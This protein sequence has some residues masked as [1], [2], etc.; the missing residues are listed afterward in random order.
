MRTTGK[1][2]VAAL[3]I[4]AGMISAPFSPL[5]ATFVVD[6]PADSHD[7][8]PGDGVAGDRAN[9][10]SSRCTLRAA[11]EEASALPGADTIL[12]GPAI[13]PIFLTL[14]EIRIEGNATSVVGV[15][16]PVIDGLHNVRFRPSLVFAADSC[17]MQGMVVKRSR[18][19]A[20]QI[21][22]S[23]CRIGDSTVD[24]RIILV[25]NG[26]DNPEAAAIRICGRAARANV[27]LGNY[28]GVDAGGLRAEPNR[29][30]IVI[31][32][33]AS[34]NIVGGHDEA[35]R[36]IISGNES[37]GLVIESGASLNKVAGNYIGTTVLA[38][39]ALGNGA[40]GLLVR[41]GANR[42]LIGGPDLTWGN[43][44]S[45]NAGSGLALSGPEVAQNTI[46]GNVIGLD[47]TGRLSLGNLADGIRL[48]SGAHANLIGGPDS[49]SGNIVSG[50]AGSGI[51]I[52]GPGSDDNN[53]VANW[54][55]VTYDGFGDVGNGWAGGDGITI[56]AAACRN[57]IGGDSY[58]ERNVVSGNYRFG[59]HLTGIGTRENL[60]AGN[61]VGT[62]AAGRSSVF[63]SAGVVIS[64]GASHNEVGGPESG[65]GNVLSGNRAAF[66]PYGAGLLIYGAGSDYN[67]VRGNLIG[68]DMRGERALRNGSAGVIIG[69]GARYNIV[70]GDAPGEGNYIAGNGSLGPIPGVA[71]GVHLY[72]AGTS[73]NRI[74]GNRIGVGPGKSGVVLSNAGHGV[75]LFAG[76]ADNIIG[77]PTP[78]GGNTI[79]ASEGHGV[80]A[81][82][83]KTRSNLIRCNLIF[84]NDSLGL[85][86]SD[87]SQAGIRP[88][89]LT[90]VDPSASGWL[91]RGEQAPPYGLVDIYETFD[92]DPSGAGEGDRYLG[93]AA[94]DSAGHFDFSLPGLTTATTTL[95]A[96]ATDVEDNTSEFAHNF[97]FGNPTSADDSPALLPAAFEL[98]FN[99]PN[100]FNGGTVI[101]FAL[102]RA[103]HTTLAIYNILGQEVAVLLDRRLSPGSYEVSWDGL[104]ASGV[105]AA[106]G[107][108][109]YRLVTDSRS[110]TRK[111]LLVK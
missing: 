109:F 34:E 111:M 46:N 95:T 41:D 102:P 108:Y 91:L 11:V 59:I 107:V 98:L 81:S 110:E 71:A 33:S 76:A 69:G 55:G 7:L 49:V 105:P 87:S 101:T 94:A 100:P 27:V 10:D 12:V 51:R 96:I 8:L 47:A 79:T 42:N 39:A 86:V 73:F 103:A 60:I 29:V 61:Y 5:A 4:L 16:S 38:D 36:N 72:G 82:G 75:G 80:I 18:D 24:G 15:G 70:G 19:D 66:F 53:I 106:S 30:G 43:L 21:L 6:S 58:Q 90:A 48:D 20:I 50:N 89:L 92:P 22:G 56:E 44:I 26:L 57:R 68:L 52:V 40:A 77:G 54:I 17:A 31:S 85:A 65:T 78:S 1:P 93:V 35:F 74:S 28:I 99:Y 14:G 64:A 67:N 37:C 32:D 62:N 9:P 13:S 84:A 45:G 88:P 3:F 25:G 97:V 2:L 104:T 63:N 83:Y 23:H